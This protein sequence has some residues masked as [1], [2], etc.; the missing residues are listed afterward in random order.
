[1]TSNTT[2]APSPIRNGVDTDAF[3]ATLDA[4]KGNHDIADFQWRATNTWISGTHNR[5]TVSGFYGAGQELTHRQPYHLDA[6]H[7]AVLVGD[8]HGPT[9][10]EYVLHALAACLTA[11]VANIAAARNVNLTRVTSTVEGD[12]DLL[13]IFGLAD[14]RSGP[15]R[16]GFKQIRVRFQLE[17]DDPA[18]LAKVV[19]QSQRRSAVFDVLT[20]GVPV[21]VDIAAG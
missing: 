10:V 17:G 8:D 1:V 3:F 2:P 4:V 18:K 13:G 12:M 6:D 16:N 19:E 11:G 5:S 9:P 14:D 20:N 7:P 15:V 21:S